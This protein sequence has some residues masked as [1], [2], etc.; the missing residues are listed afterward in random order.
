LPACWGLVC[1]QINNALALAGLLGLL[2]GLLALALR[3]A[4]S[5]RRLDPEI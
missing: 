4:G 5:A 3:D 1:R 2:I